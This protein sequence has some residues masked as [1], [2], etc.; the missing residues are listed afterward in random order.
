MIVSVAI[1]GVALTDF[2]LEDA[3]QTSGAV[4][5]TLI[6]LFGYYL[7]IVETGFKA[8]YQEPLLAFSV[9]LA[10]IIFTITL[11]Y[12][13]QTALEKRI[14]KIAIVPGLLSLFIATAAVFAYALSHL[15]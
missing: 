5:P 10:L 8:F 2:L 9:L 11:F 14:A 7:Y 13:A 12:C 3:L 6:G 15:S 1:L 4:L